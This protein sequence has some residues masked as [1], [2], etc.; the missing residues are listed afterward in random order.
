MGKRA[1]SMILAVALALSVAVGFVSAGSNMDDATPISLGTRYNDSITDLNTQ[2]Y[3]QFNLP[4]SGRLKLQITT[5]I[6]KTNFALLDGNGSTVWEKTNQTWNSTSHEY[7]LD[8]DVDLTSGIYYFVVRQYGNS[9]GDYSFT[10]TCTS[11]NESFPETTGGTNN[12]MESAS[13]ISAGRTYYGQIANNDAVDYYKVTLTKSGRLHLDLAAAIYKTDYAFYDAN[14]YTLWEKTN[15]TWNKETNVYSLEDDFDVTAGTYYFCV[16]QYLRTGNYSFK[17]SDTDA[18][19]S[20]P[21]SAGGVDNEM[22]TANQ[23]SMETTYRGQIALND[24]ADF[25]RVRLTESGTM[26]LRITT[27][28]YK[29]DLSLLDE[30]GYTV[31]QK[32][33]ATWNES[34]H[35]CSLNEYVK[36]NAG[37]YYFVARYY[38]GTGNYQ[39]SIEKGPQFSDVRES[40]FFFN[41]VMWAVE[42]SVTGGTDETHFSPNKTVMRSDSMVFFWAAKGRPAHRDIQSPFK[43]VKKKHWFYDAV[44]WAVENSITAGTDATHFSPN[45]TCSRSE[46]LQF[47]Y[48]A[49]NRPAYTIANPYSDVKK[50]HWYYDGAIWAY[51]NGLEKGENGKFNAKTPCTRGYVVTYLFRFI[52]GK[53]LAQ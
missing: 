3:F 38:L 44:L 20:F 25:Y 28:I 2:D 18:N 49:M 41:P 32:E 29:T 42:N 4:E 21:E 37:T 19:E 8:E 50:S 9:T 31:W 12:D 33:R 7:N 52:T 30:N 22:E 47:L 16:R 6:Y 51:E 1:L 11:A 15:Q 43:D 23:I 40:D 36:L 26:R 10:L 35:E 45:N 24:L 27:Q 46:I 13:A 5:H 17:L 14:G 39:F 48:A 34:T 53:E